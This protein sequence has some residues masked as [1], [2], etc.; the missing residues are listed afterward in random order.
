MARWSTSRCKYCGSELHK[1][2]A[3]C[4]ACGKRL[5]SRLADPLTRKVILMAAVIVGVLLLKAWIPAVFQQ[6]AP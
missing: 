6:L 4:P 3:T 1:R 5:K 2:A